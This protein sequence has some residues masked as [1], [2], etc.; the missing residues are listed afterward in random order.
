MKRNHRRLQKTFGSDFI[1]SLIDGLDSDDINIVTKSYSTLSPL[2]ESN[3]HGN[4]DGSSLQYSDISSLRERLAGPAER[5]LSVL[6]T[7]ATNRD[8]HD[9]GLVTMA[10][11]ALAQLMER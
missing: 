6:C 7:G 8:I 3:D 11:R 10:C 5:A 1:Q 4:P 9:V 2:A